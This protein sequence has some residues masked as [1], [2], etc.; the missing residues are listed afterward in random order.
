M[1][2]E[3]IRVQVE[4]SSGIIALNRPEKH[5]ALSSE[6]IYEVI[7]ALRAFEEDDRVR[8]V[9]LTGNDRAFS[10]GADLNQALKVKDGADLLRYNRVWRTLTYQIEHL[11]K[12]VIAAIE[13]YC[14][15]G[16]LE[17]AM[18]CDVRIASENATFGITSSKI[19]SVAGAGGTQRLPRLV[20]PAIARELL[21][22]S[23]FIGSDEAL[24]IGLINKV[25]PTGKA[26]E[27]AMDMVSIFAQRGPLSIAWMKVAV[28][29][30][31]NLD[32]ESALDL[33]ASLSA[34]A[35][36]TADKEE[37]MSA[38]LEKRIATFHGR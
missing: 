33:E 26:V 10:T 11:I 17:V 38:F 2:Y 12:P 35:F 15:T 27:A 36:G 7:D 18:S 1:N 24:R 25:A 19:G 29:V 30:G 23:N 21:F 32:L 3:F 14:L 13:G 28:N 8:G 31:M 37:G 22:T 4:G 16:G 6:L 5:N 9:I 20:G 34:Q